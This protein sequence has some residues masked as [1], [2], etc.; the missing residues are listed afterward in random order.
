MRA[1]P[2]LRLVDRA[3]LLVSGAFVI[4]CLI[5]PNSVRAVSLP[6]FVAATL[7][8][9]A[10]GRACVHPPALRMWAF[11]AMITMVYLIVGLPQ[12]RPEAF[13]QTIFVYAVAPLCWIIV[14]S[15]LVA[16]VPLRTLA[17]WLVAL[18]AAGATTVFAYYYVFFTLGPDAL[19]WLIAEPN[20]NVSDGFAGAAMHVFGPLIF[21]T[22]ALWAAPS[23]VRAPVLRA[24][25]LF[26]LFV[27]AIMSGRTALMLSIPI[28]L[29]VFL[30]T[31]PQ[32][33]RRTLALV[34]AGMTAAALLGMAAVVLPDATGVDPAVI[35]ES[36][37]LKIQEG[38]GEDRILQAESLWRGIANNHLLGSGHGVGVEVVRNDDYP[39]RY[40]LL[41][42]AT[43]FRVG[44][45]GTAVYALPVAFVFVR[46]LMRGGSGRPA[47]SD[48]FVFAGFLGALIASATNPYFESFEFQWMLIYPM[49]HFALD[50]SRRRS[51]P[52]ATAPS[53]VGSQRV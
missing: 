21:V 50:H 9:L 38:G 52:P 26:T 1:S 12:M 19:I 39:W 3:A 28:G 25:A 35:L 49:V 47:A 5:V 43:L 32:A 30:T 22:A 14:C 36:A 16:V 10:T 8:C 51:A 4:V 45:L 42:L 20:V 17:L 33:L 23:L 29:L 7:L 27:V 24:L 34:A 15:Y 13:E 41:W 46:F 31:G 48:I 40:E 53:D 6:L 18:G 11:S 44:I 37:F 2:P